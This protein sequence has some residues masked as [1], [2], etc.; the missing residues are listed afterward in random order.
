MATAVARTTVIVCF[1][2]GTFNNF[3]ALHFRLGKICLRLKIALGS[4]FDSL[5]L[6]PCEDPAKTEL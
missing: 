4:L 3:L 2:V 5:F 6:P 1:S